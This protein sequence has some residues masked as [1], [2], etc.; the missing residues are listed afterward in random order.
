MRNTQSSPSTLLVVDDSPAE[1]D[2]VSELLTLEGFRVIEA[3]DGAQALGLLRA[4]RRPDLIL[5]DLVMAGMSGWEFRIAQR[6]APAIAHIPVIAMSGANSAEARAIDARAFVSKPIIR[7]QLLSAVRS[8]LQQ[9]EARQ[10]EQMEKLASLGRLAASIAHEV[11]NPLAFAK[12]NLGYLR[13]ELLIPVQSGE[14]LPVQRLADCA[15]ALQEAED[16]LERI[17]MIVKD[18]LL[19]G[20]TSEG[21]QQLVDPTEAARLALKVATGRLRGVE[22]SLDFDNSVRVRVDSDRLAQV[23]L[24][25]IVNAADALQER[26]ESERR[27]TVS[28]KRAGSEVEIAVKDSGPGISADVKARLFEPFF[29]TKP[30]GLGTGLGLFVCR[31]LV[32]AMAGRMEI[33]S[34]VGVGTTARVL[35]P[36]SNG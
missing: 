17:E 1:R 33:E 35:L 31:G 6:E 18:I 5:L 9:S 23:L 25:L 13:Q 36:A 4:G 24:N 10:L 20:R 27:L 26:P 29:T 12:S 16:G 3:H 30:A 15:A 28:I 22:I 34:A 21:G 7:D 8:V 14:Q 11:N 32:E 19:F 2:A